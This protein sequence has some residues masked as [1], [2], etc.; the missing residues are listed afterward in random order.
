MRILVIG[1]ALGLGAC[2]AGPE[3][4]PVRPVAETHV[5]TQS[6]DGLAECR[7]IEPES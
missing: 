6:P 4:G 5:C 3:R 2:A 7:T 1:L